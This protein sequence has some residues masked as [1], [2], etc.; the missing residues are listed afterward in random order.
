[1]YQPFLFLCIL[2]TK[3]RTADDAS[4]CI[5]ISINT[6]F[7]Q[8]G[9]KFSLRIILWYIFQ[10]LQPCILI[11]RRFPCFLIYS[12]ITPAPPSCTLRSVLTGDLFLYIYRYNL[13]AGKV[14]LIF[15]CI[16]FNETMIISMKLSIKMPEPCTRLRHL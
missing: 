12:S 11:Q 10:N 5:P 2:E 7:C 4:Q 8:P 13:S 1:M 6:Y 16:S 3:Y 14:H 15:N 9:F